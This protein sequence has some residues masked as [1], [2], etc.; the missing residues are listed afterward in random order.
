MNKEEVK[1][2]LNLFFDALEGDLKFYRQLV[3]SGNTD[4]A[5]EL[6]QELFTS[7][8]DFQNTTIDEFVELVKKGD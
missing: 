6:I 8:L 5:W 1:G 3:N 2:Y 4:E 7:P